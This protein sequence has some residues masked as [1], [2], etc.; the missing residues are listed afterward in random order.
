MIL[1]ISIA[2]YSENCIKKFE[3]GKKLQLLLLLSTSELQGRFVHSQLCH[4]SSL[5]FVY[6]TRISIVGDWE[7]PVA[8]AYIWKQSVIAWH[9]GI[10]LTC[11]KNLFYDVLFCVSFPDFF[12]S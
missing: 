9:F 2:R 1:S 6:S 10:F 3:R 5:Q 8:A 12:P 11:L 7:F 4:Y